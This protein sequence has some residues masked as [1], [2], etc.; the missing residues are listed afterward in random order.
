MSIV[1][2]S[3]LLLLFLQWIIEGQFD[4][5]QEL[6]RFQR[7]ELSDAFKIAPKLKQY[8]QRRQPAERASEEALFVD[9]L[10]V[11]VHAGWDLSTAMDRVSEHMGCNYLEGS[12]VADE[13]ELAMKSNQELARALPRIS[14]KLKAKKTSQV[15]SIPIGVLLLVAL[16]AFS[17]FLFFLEARGLFSGGGSL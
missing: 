4:R 5:Q 1:L 9:M 3:I 11:S 2:I 17:Y 7:H 13:I 12:R 15:A 6:G 14:R 10:D 16:M 8:F